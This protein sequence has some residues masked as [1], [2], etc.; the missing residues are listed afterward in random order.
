MP[1][2]QVEHRHLEHLEPQRQT[3]PVAVDQGQRGRDVAARRR[4][5]HADA[6]G[7]DTQLGGVGEEPLQRGMGLLDLGGVAVL[8]RQGVV[9]RD[10]R[11]AGICGTTPACGIR[12]GIVDAADAEGPA[13]EGEA[14]RHG[15]VRLLRV[16]HADAHGRIPAHRHLVLADAQLWARG[17]D[18]LEFVAIPRERC[19]AVL[20]TGA[21]EPGEP[22]GAFAGAA[23]LRALEIP[24]RGDPRAQILHRLADQVPA[25]HAEAFREERIQRHAH[26]FPSPTGPRNDEPAGTRRW[27]RF[28]TG[29]SCVVRLVLT[30]STW[31]RR[32]ARHGVPC[33]GSGHAR[34][35][36]S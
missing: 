33:H 31:S 22:A 1:A 14:G 29:M 28:P 13:E 7:I 20:R 32:A 21:P 18:G 3:A 25:V 24:Q 2:R 15:S 26:S 16:I 35:R 10:H 27:P 17:A 4:A 12:R 19:A 23:G 11:D 5:R 34:C 8:G 6:F 9:D 36:T 30:S